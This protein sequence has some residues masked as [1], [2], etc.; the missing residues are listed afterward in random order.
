LYDDYRRYGLTEAD[1]GG[2]TYIRIGRI[3][4]LISQ[5]RLD[6]SLRWTAPAAFT[7]AASTHTVSI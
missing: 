5:G 4:E 3:R 1:L 7:A 2:S 6:A